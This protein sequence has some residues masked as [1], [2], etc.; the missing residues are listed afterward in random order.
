MT[1]TGNPKRN[2]VTVHV[3]VT[4]TNRKKRPVPAQLQ[5]GSLPSGSIARRAEIWIRRLCEDANE[6]TVAARNLYAG[7]HW[8]IVRTL[9]D[10][11]SN[12]ENVRLWVC[13]AGYGLIPV[14]AQIRPYAATFSAGF[15]DS[16]AD[17]PDEAT[18]WWDLLGQWP[19]PCPSQHRSLCALTQ[20]DQAAL[21]MLVLSESYLRACR[22]DISAALGRMG[23]SDRFLIVSSARRQD[24]LAPVMVPADARLQAYFGGTRQALNARIAAHLLSVG[25]RSLSQATAHLEQLLEAQPPLP[26]YDRKKLSDDEVLDLIAERLS[27]SPATSASALLRQIRDAGYACEQ[28]RFAQLYHLA[29]EVPS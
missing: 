14:D 4:C 8:T 16:V 25:I 24:G 28:Q 12:T 1:A 5:L 21:Y 26:R 19:G 18:D 6:P 20:A 10:L 15:P 7:E 23:A 13:S 22:H 27:R 29:M 2:P 9:P 3:V 11:S 17:S